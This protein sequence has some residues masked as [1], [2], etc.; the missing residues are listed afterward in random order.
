MQREDGHSKI[1]KKES[2]LLGGVKRK[3]RRKSYIESKRETEI[4][5]FS[6]SSFSFFSWVA[7]VAPLLFYFLHPLYFFLVCVGKRRPNA[8]IYFFVSLPWGYGLK[9]KRMTNASPSSSRWFSTPCRYCSSIF[10]LAKRLGPMKY[11]P[12]THILK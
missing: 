12:P 3:G 8:S 2:N 11:A 5:M 1:R 7:R 10:A 6:T 4:G 9:R